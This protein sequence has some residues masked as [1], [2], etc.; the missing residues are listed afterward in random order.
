MKDFR[1]II[2]MNFSHAQKLSKLERYRNLYDFFLSKLERYRNLY[3]FFFLLFF[4]P[5][6]Y[7]IVTQIV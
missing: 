5:F 2:V 7:I 1:I 3:D 4:F 6:T